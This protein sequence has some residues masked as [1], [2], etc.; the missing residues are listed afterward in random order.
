MNFAEKIHVLYYKLPNFTK[1]GILGKVVDKL[2]AKC[3]KYLLD[4]YMPKY[5]K[6]NKKSLFESGK[7]IE[8]LIVSLTSFPAR[9]NDVWIPI[10]SILHQSRL[11]ERVILYLTRS[12]FTDQ[13]LPKSLIDLKK[14][15]LEIKFVNDDIKAHTK[16][17]YALNDFPEYLVITIDDDIYYDNYMIENLLNL[18]EAYPKS[19]IANR[20]HKIK[21]NGKELLPYRKWEHN[22]S[23]KTNSHELFATGVY[24]ILYQNELLSAHY[25]DKYV[26]STKC[27]QADDVWLKI[28]ELLKGTKVATNKRYGKDPITVGRSQKVRLNFGNVHTG[29]NDEQLKAVLEHFNLS[30]DDFK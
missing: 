17:F 5:Y 29:G 12:Q 15:G 3:L 24:G 6:T 30:V 13:E 11:P 28:M 21:Y 20:V 27:M 19:I 1:I 4:S 16:Y 2:L 10:E 22:Y 18:H 7:K 9:I 23:K 25:K 26:L 8:G 14:R